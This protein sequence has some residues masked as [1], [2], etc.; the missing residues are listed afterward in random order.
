MNASRDAVAVEP[1]LGDDVELGT[2]TEALTL[3]PFAVAALPVLD[4][5]RDETPAVGLA[6][7]A[8]EGGDARD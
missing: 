4:R 1:L 3:A 2:A 6:V 8:A 5:R 7:A